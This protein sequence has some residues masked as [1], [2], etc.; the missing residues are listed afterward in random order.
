MAKG[1]STGNARPATAAAVNE[2]LLIAGLH[3][4]ELTAAAEELNAQLR[5]EVAEH[6]KTSAALNEAVNELKRTQAIAERAGQAKDAFFATLSH[7]LRTPLTPVLM[8]AAALRDDA[9]LPSDAREQLGMVERN[10]ALEARLIDDLLDI[11]KISHGKLQYRPEPCDA[12]SLINFAVQIVRAEARAKDIAI[13]CTLAAPQSGLLADPT[14]FQQIVWNLLRNAVKFTPPGGRIFVRTRA[15]KTAG[16]ESWLRLEV[17]DSGIGID[18]ARLD[19]IFLPFDQGGLAG[20]HRFGGVGLG[21]AIARA[22]VDLHG[23]WISARSAGPGCG[24]TFVVE[25]P[26][27]AEPPASSAPAAAAATTVSTMAAPASAKVA[28]RR[29]LVVEDDR[30]TL[31]TTCYLLQRQG[32]HVTAAS[33]IAEALAAAATGGFDLVISDLGLP[34]GKGVDLMEKLGMT[35]GLKG[36]ALSGYGTEEDIAS[37]RAAGFIAHLIKPV[38]IAELCREIAAACPT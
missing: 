32:H 30:S 7:E 18:P 26:G 28:P 27:A 23:G 34:D 5:A 31:R 14:R 25:L 19:T 13:E 22:V 17:E 2:A 38:T 11:T 29:L 21:L 37:S 33:S 9:R 16:R 4:H 6:R 12:H 35:H 20:D 1:Q 36:I 24:A 8:T 10:I 3:Q 15:D